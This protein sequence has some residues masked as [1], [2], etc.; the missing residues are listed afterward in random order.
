MERLKKPIEPAALDKEIMRIKLNYPD[1]SPRQIIRKAA[2]SFNISQP[3]KVQ[4]PECL[5]LVDP[6]ELLV[7]N[8]VCETCNELKL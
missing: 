3:E 1:L 6:D 2:R 8:G 7:F 4:C 5:T